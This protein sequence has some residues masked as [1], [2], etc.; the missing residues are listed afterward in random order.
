MQLE[1]P[2]LHLRVSG[3]PEVWP[4]AEGFRLRNGAIARLAWLPMNGSPEQGQW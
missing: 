3:L 2:Y 4:S 1:G